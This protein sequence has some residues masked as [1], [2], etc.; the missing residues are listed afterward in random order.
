MFQPTLL[1]L[2]SSDSASRT[3]RRWASRFQPT[4]LTLVS[5]DFGFAFCWATS[6]FQ[7]TL[8]TLVSSD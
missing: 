2:V 6:P 8:L 3:P 4:L 1:T 7:P 5:S